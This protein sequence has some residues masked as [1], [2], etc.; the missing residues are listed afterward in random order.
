MPIAPTS[1]LMIPFTNELTMFVKAAPMTTATAR[2]TTLPRIR[3]ALKPCQTLGSFF[4]L[5]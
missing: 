2:S 1:G 5:T 3:K 4:A